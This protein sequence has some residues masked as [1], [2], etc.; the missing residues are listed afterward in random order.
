MALHGSHIPRIVAR[1]QPS[2]PPSPI[3]HLV[4]LS[5]PPFLLKY[6]LH[7]S[8]DGACLHLLL[9][10][11]FFFDSDGAPYECPALGCYP[12]SSYPRS[13][14]FLSRAEPQCSNGS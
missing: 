9:A 14:L 10:G 1:R 12:T 13:L 3:D 5:L 6:I 11:F 8:T 7:S 4:A 2:P